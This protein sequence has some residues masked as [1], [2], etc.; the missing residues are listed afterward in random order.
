MNA[1][2]KLPRLD[3]CLAAPATGR[4]SD[5]ACGDEGVPRATVR[6]GALASKLAQWPSCIRFFSTASAAVYSRS[7][8][9]SSHQFVEALAQ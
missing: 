4:P 9:P 1:R 3:V 2:C 7:V 6:L 5:R 8:V